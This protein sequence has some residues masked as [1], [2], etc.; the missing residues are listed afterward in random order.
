MQ[1]FLTR[2]KNTCEFFKQFGRVRPNISQTNHVTLLFLDFWYKRILHT[3]HSSGHLFRNTTRQTEH[4]H[5][6]FHPL[7]QNIR[8]P[9]SHVSSGW[10]IQMGAAVRF[11]TSSQNLK[12][13]K[14]IFSVKFIFVLNTSCI[15]KFIY[16]MICI[17]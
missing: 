15:S 10:E 7:S 12:I 9:F 13:S 6:A 16:G 17:R 2:V 4:Q 3:S 5:Y 8:V 14:I 11:L 1:P